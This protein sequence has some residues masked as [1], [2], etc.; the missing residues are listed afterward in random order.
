[1]E[2]NSASGQSLLQAQDNVLIITDPKIIHLM[3]G[4]QALRHIC[5]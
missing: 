4:N 1:M 3:S 5:G 2:D